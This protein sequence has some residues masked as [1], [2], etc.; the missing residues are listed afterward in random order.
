[1]IRL[2]N[3]QFR[4][5]LVP[6]LMTLVM[7]AVLLGLGF[8]QVERAKWKRGIVENYQHNSGAAPLSALPP[9]AEAQAYTYRHVVLGGKYQHHLSIELRPR[10]VY[11]KMGYDLVTPFTLYT[12][13]VIL[14]LRG[15]VPDETKEAIDQPIGTVAASGELRPFSARYWR[16]ENQ[17]DKGQ[18][19]WLDPEAI[20]VKHGLKNPYPL[21][22]I[23]EEKPLNTPWPAPQMAEPYFH[24]FHV[25]Y[26]ITWFF[27]AVALLCIYLQVHIVRK[28]SES[29]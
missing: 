26:A 23:A 20:A 16:P 2:K 6:T 11:G 14:V 1:M 21:L 4:P 8:W 18:W 27:L 9:A 7:L 10:A 17:P 25:A 3:Y 19:Y 22:L 5:R 15:F 24:D 28:N 29:Q 13:E 12:G